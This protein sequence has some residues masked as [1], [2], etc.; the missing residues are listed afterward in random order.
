MVTIK[1]LQKPSIIE[2]K[3]SV[4]RIAHPNVLKYTRTG[5]ASPIAAAGTA[6]TVLDNDDFNDDDWFIIGEPGDEKTEE[7]DV[8]GAVTRGTSVTVTNTLKFAHE[9]D[10]PVK[11]IYERKFTVYGSATDGGSLTAIVATGS[12]LDI[13]WGKPYSEY[14]L[15]T[16][17]TTYA[18]YVVKF[19][20]GTT[21]SSASDYV[22]STGLADSSASRISENALDITGAIIDSD[23][24]WDF[25]IRSIQDAQNTITQYVN[26]STGIK[27]DWSF[28]M[29]EDRTSIEVDTLEDK[30]ALSA[31][32]SAMKYGETTQSILTVR[33]GDRVLKG[34]PIDELDSFRQGRI[35]TLVA[36][37]ASIGA[38]TLVVDDVTEFTDSGTLNAKGGQAI[39]YTAFTESTN[40]FSGIPASGTGSI[41]VA[42]SVGDAIW[43][44][45]SGGIS[46]YYTVFDG[47]IIL[48]RPPSSDYDGYPLKIRYI[49]N[50]TAITEQSDTTEIPFYSIIQYYVAWKIEMR[51]KN[52]E[53]AEYF[54]QKFDALL[55]QNC[56]S[57]KSYTTDTTTY[58]NF[59]HDPYSS[60]YTNA[61]RTW[62]NM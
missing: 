1:S 53:Q 20:D 12:A 40:T 21:E 47:S 22:A 19:Y 42:L 7:N 24:T 18:F 52:F 35:K 10:A 32:T 56:I 51:R 41:T 26:A 62:H 23:I 8:N 48:D 15:K 37:A 2:I 27:K 31:L 25:L 13:M 29:V 3:N 60:D 36:T 38:T 57:D 16:A 44:N 45:E 39:T 54:K 33:F 9:I 61:T 28:E 49:K 30:Y 4:I 5:L 43:Q 50:L 17:D 59:E 11:R 34:I 14:T 55:L 6:M 46:S 58:F